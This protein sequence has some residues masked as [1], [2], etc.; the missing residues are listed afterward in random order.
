MLRIIS[1]EWNQVMPNLNSAISSTGTIQTFA[2]I[3]AFLQQPIAALRL[4]CGS[5]RAIKK[6]ELIA[7]DLGKAL[8]R[9]P[10]SSP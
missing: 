7:V 10:S 5:L 1:D 9:S 6:L 4:I 3:L 8:V 2:L